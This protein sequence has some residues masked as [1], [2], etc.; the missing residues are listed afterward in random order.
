ML[1]LI[2]KLFWFDDDGGPE[3]PIDCP[4]CGPW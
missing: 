2:F 3:Q 1:K 4:E